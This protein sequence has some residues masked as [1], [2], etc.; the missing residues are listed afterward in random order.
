MAE[1]KLYAGDTLELLVQQVRLALVLGELSPRLLEVRLTHLQLR[2]GPH[3]LQACRRSP[4]KN[5]E[6]ATWPIAVVR[7][8]L[9]RAQGYK[10]RRCVLEPAGAVRR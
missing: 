6:H 8:K 3:R 2:A 5:A 10:S 1:R 4:G 9:A 7:W